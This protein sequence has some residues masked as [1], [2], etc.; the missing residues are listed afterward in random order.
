MSVTIQTTSGPVTINE[1]RQGKNI[2]AKL[3]EGFFSATVFMTPAQAMEI[4]ST[5]AKRAIEAGYSGTLLAVDKA[6]L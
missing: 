6:T 2:S 3:G 5:L 4:A 1:V